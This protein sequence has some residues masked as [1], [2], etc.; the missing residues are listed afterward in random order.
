MD[1]NS[2]LLFWV[3][4]I[5]CDLNKIAKAASCL[6]LGAAF[7]IDFCFVLITGEVFI[8]HYL[9]LRARLIE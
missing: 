6:Y 3:L 2:F 5:R 1:E 8:K 7:Y 4:I 9:N